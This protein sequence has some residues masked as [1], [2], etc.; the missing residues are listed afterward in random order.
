ME[1]FRA[2]KTAAQ[3]GNREEAHRLFRRAIEIDPYHIQVWLWLATVVETDED[4]I[5][6]FQNVLE[7]DPHH[8]TARR[9]LRR[10]QD[11]K[12][13][14]VLN[15]ESTNQKHASQPSRRFKILFGLTVIVTVLGG[16]GLIAFA[17]LI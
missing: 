13:A 2:G 5:V 11:K 17:L 12:I 6:C 9:R 15:Q 1:L 3:Q 10:L 16:I 14:E 4:Q 7:I 8:L